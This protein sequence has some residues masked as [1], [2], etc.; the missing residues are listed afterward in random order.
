M[1]SS[2]A[3]AAWDGR[4]LPDDAAFAAL[5]ADLREPRARDLATGEGRLARAAARLNSDL[6][7]LRS[8]LPATARRVAAETPD[9][10]TAILAAAPEWSEIEAWGA[11]RRALGPLTG[12]HLQQTIDVKRDATGAW[13]EVPDTSGTLP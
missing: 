12:L 10:R 13:R 7:G 2:G 11:I 4:A 8:A 6:P 3:L 5:A 1:P 9:T